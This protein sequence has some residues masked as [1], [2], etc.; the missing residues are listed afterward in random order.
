MFTHQLYG[1]SEV[2]RGYEPFAEDDGGGFNRDSDSDSGS[3]LSRSSPLSDSTVDDGKSSHHKAKGF[4]VKFDENC[5]VIKRVKFKEQLE[6]KGK[7]FV[8]KDAS[9]F[10]DIH[11]YLSPCC[12]KCEVIYECVERTSKTSESFL[13]NGS[14]NDAND[15]LRND[16][17]FNINEES[18]SSCIVGAESNPKLPIEDVL[19]RLRKALPPDTMIHRRDNKHRRCSGSLCN[20]FLKKIIGDCKI[21]KTYSRKGSTFVLALGDGTDKAIAEYHTKVQNLSM[22]FIETADSVDI[23]TEDDGRWKV[24]YLFCK[25]G[26]RQ[27]SLAAYMT[28]FYFNAPLKRPKGGTIKR[29]CQALV[30]PPYQR[31]GHGREMLNAVYLNAYRDRKKY[32]LLMYISKLA[33]Y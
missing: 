31:A 19:G 13:N 18:S 17:V 10:L 22:W 27:Y 12:T 30:F 4:G 8:T 3:N 33:L 9:S 14:S 20:T 7:E 25:H 16:A 1:I 11:V 5:R 28:L 6:D 23:S 21:L 29:V 24:L 15:G 32:N 2:I 26:E